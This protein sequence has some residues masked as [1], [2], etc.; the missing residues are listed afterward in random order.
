[1]LL[2][3]TIDTRLNA[4]ERFVFPNL[5]QCLET[6]ILGTTRRWLPVPH[7]PAKVYETLFL[8]GVLPQGAS[9]HV[10]D[11]HIA[12]EL[13]RSLMRDKGLRACDVLS[14]LGRILDEPGRQEGAC[15]R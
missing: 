14:A 15:H 13:L 1:M 9:Q 5:M 12:E 10:A 3:R 8:R 2:N 4:F 7:F 11:V 6:S